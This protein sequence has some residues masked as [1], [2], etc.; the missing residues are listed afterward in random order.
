MSLPPVLEVWTLRSSGAWWSKNF[1]FFGRIH[2]LQNF[3]NFWVG[4]YKTLG[5]SRKINF[6]LTPFCR[7]FREVLFAHFGQFF[8]IFRHIGKNF[9]GIIPAS[10]FSLLGSPGNG[11]GTGPGLDSRRGAPIQDIL[12]DIN[13]EKNDKYQEEIQIIRRIVK[14]EMLPKHMWRNHGLICHIGWFEA[15]NV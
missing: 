13:N 11:G 7:E 9:P 12:F 15:Q 6:I 10:I 1:C 4:H 8:T 2:F 5:N 3:G 14:L